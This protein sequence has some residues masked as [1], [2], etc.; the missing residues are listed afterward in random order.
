MTTLKHYRLALQVFQSNRLRRDYSDLAEIEQY[1]PVGEFFFTE[2]YG[3]RDFADRDAGARRLHHIIQMLP[4]VHL[5]DVEEVLD[6]LELTN[7]LDDDLARLML[8]LGTGI[9]FDEATYEH[10]YRVAN[11]YDAR[12]YQLNLVNSSLHNVYRL[13]RSHLLGM[14]LHRS[15]LLA[16]LAGIEAAHTF[17]VRGYDALRDVNDITLFADTV[18]SRELARLN[19]IYGRCDP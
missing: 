12:L 2:M 15:H 6:L 9:D 16:V 13:S 11:N 14:G 1:G 17:L 3:P 19:R 18:R 4:G 10:A 8:E 7:V 5:N